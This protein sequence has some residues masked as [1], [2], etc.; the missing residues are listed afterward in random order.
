MRCHFGIFRRIGGTIF[1]YRAFGLN[2]DSE[3]K[4]PELKASSH[5]EA[6]VFIS[7]GE[8]P[9]KMDDAIQEGVLFEAKPDDFLLTMDGVAR[10][11]VE[12]GQNI[13][14]QKIGDTWKRLRLYLLGSCMGAILLQR[15]QMVLHAN[16]VEID[17]RAVAFSG[18]SGAGKSTL[19]AAFLQRGHKLVADDVTTI[20]MEGSGVC[21]EPGFPRVKLWEDSAK[22]LGMGIENLDRIMGN[23]N[24]YSLFS[25][26]QFVSE[27]RP[28]SHVYILNA[29]NEDKFKLKE[30]KG[31]EKFQVLKTN[32]YRLQYLFGLGLEQEHFKLCAQ[33]AP[34]FKVKVLTRPNY[35]FRL[36]QLV[37]KVEKDLAA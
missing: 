30:I 31:I 37:K 20:H 18:H 9:E 21:A 27:S 19:C 8:V 17:G 24:K 26:R 2:I 33:V 13:T 29:A 34:H 32:S 7:N 1:R 14:I 4:L 36:K 25:R 12:N 5:R 16:T 23:V 3:I 6:D 11:R 35:P 10:F 15:K 28:L 22:R